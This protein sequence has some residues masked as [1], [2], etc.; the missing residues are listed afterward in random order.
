MPVILQIA[1]GGA[2]G[3]MLRHAAV[4]ASARAFGSSFPYGVALVNIAGS[5]AMGLVVALVALRADTGWARSAPFLMAGLLGG[6][7]TFSAFSLDA[8]ALVEQGRIGAALVYVAGSVALSIAALAA[9]L[10]LTRA[11]LAP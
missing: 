5:F 3:A 1:L 8:V 9:A 6:F 7:T 11:W 4:T 10:A 2:L